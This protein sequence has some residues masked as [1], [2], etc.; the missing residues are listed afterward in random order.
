MMLQVGRVDSL[1]YNSNYELQMWHTYCNDGQLSLIFR[2]GI[3][4]C[5]LQFSIILQNNLLQNTN[6]IYMFQQW[7]TVAMVTIVT[8]VTHNTC[9]H[10]AQY[11]NIVPAGFSQYCLHTRLCHNK[12][13]S[14]QYCIQHSAY[15]LLQVKFKAWPFLLTVDTSSGMFSCL[16]T[17]FLVFDISAG[18]CDILTF[19][20]QM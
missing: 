14:L 5:T 20:P 11:L 10:A 12:S 7:R 6:M 18:F 15:I 9:W 1:H 3:I 19:D 8:M 16:F 2:L 17:S 13:E 4:R